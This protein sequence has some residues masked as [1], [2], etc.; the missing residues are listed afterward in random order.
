[1]PILW[2]DEVEV[3]V[4][5]SASAVHGVCGAG[6]CDGT[7]SL[8]VV[9]WTVFEGLGWEVS[10]ADVRRWNGKQRERDAAGRRIPGVMRSSRG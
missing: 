7:E 4:L 10:L 2:L 6:S 3:A 5:A 8:D 1:M 9:L